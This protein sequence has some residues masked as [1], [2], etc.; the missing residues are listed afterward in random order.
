MLGI[1]PLKISLAKTIVDY[2]EFSIALN[3]KKEIAI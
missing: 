1:H 2:F 3:S